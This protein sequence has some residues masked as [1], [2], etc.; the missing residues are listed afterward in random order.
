MLGSFAIE[1]GST[2]GRYSSAFNLIVYSFQR[3]INHWNL[4]WSVNQR[5]HS[6]QN[7]YVLIMLIII[8]IIIIIIIRIIIIIVII[9]IINWR[10]IYK[11]FGLPVAQPVE[12][13]WP[14]AFLYVDHT[15]GRVNDV[16]ICRVDDGW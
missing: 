3:S 12:L 8:I 2:V 1:G 10:A 6:S 16:V 4:L 15:V 13:A 9:I 5:K 7:G 14:L 11:L